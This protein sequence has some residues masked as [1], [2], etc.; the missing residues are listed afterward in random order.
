LFNGGPNS[1]GD[2]LRI[3]TPSSLR[4]NRLLPT[5]LAPDDAPTVTAMATKLIADTNP[6]TP[7][8]DVPAFVGELPELPKMLFKEGG[9]IVKLFRNRKIVRGLASLNLAEQFGWRP[10]IGD[11]VKLLRF[12]SEV[13]RRIKILNTAKTEGRVHFKRTLYKGARQSSNYNS[14]I[15]ADV[16][17]GYLLNIWGAIDWF[18]DGEL[19]GTQE[20]MRRLADRAVHGLNEV[21]LATAWQLMPWSWLVDWCSNIGTFLNTT[22]NGIPFTHSTPQIMVHMKRQAS[23]STKSY[24]G[25]LYNLSE[26]VFTHET[27]ERFPTPGGFPEAKLPFLTNSQ[28]SILASIGVTHRRGG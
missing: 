25:G 23:H 3:N 2:D 13:D 24:F 5:I 7:Y 22:R 6:N 27:K 28:F 11:L 9:E 16:W 18:P 4:A 1:S 8:V 10:F 20:E 15:D 17:Q 19:P 14:N 26:G 12:Q 21:S